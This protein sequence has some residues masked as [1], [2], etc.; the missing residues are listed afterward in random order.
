MNISPNHV[1]RVINIGLAY[2]GT[3]SAALTPELVRITDTT[4]KLIFEQ[5]I[6]TGA[7]SLKFPVNI[8][9]GIYNVLIFANGVQMATQKIQVY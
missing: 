1:H 5:L 4:G 8:D 2:T 6:E 7:T 9:P 3:V